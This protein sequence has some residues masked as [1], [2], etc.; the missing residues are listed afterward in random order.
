[1]SNENK[2][3][4]QY[5]EALSMKKLFDLMQIW[6]NEKGKRLLSLSIEKDTDKFCC[7]AL[8]NP[9]EVAIVDGGEGSADVFHGALK[10]RM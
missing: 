6:Q 2:H 7:I 4:I 10:V 5:F 8:T 1:M 3:N 9:T